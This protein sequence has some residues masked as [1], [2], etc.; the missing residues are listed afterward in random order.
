[1]FIKQLANRMSAPVPPK[2][3]ALVLSSAKVVLD[4]NGS[5]TVVLR[6]WLS[7][8]RISALNVVAWF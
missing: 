4:I 1:M 3:Q 8:W 6:Q 7:Y 5:L 2:T